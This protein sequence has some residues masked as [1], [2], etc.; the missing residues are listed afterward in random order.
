MPPV[1]CI[2][3]LSEFGE[4]VSRVPAKTYGGEHTCYMQIC[5]QL[6]ERAHVGGTD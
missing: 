5:N 3:G 4:F 6:D 1:F 2:G